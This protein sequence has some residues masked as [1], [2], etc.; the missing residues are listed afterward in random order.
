MAAVSGTLDEKDVYND[1]ILLVLLLDL[2]ENSCSN[3]SAVAS[4]FFSLAAAFA[5]AEAHQSCEQRDLCSWMFL[6]P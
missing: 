1:C 5:I 4:L 6:A 3:S 2:F